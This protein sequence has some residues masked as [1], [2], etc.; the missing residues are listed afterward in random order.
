MVLDTR[1]PLQVQTPDFAGIYADTLKARDQ[2]M[3]AA[4]QQEEMAMAKQQKNR[5]AQVYSQAVNPQTGAV[6]RNMLFKGLAGAGRGDLVPTLQTEFAQ[7]DKAQ[8]EAAQKK[9]ELDILNTRTAREEVARA[10]GKNDAVDVARRF[11]AKGVLDPETA[12]S[13]VQSI[14]DDPKGFKQWQRNFSMQL[15]DAEKRMDV[16]YKQGSLAVQQGQLNV[17]RGNLAVNQGRLAL[18]AIKASREPRLG[19]PKP[20]TAA[21]DAKLR[22]T[23]S[24][25]FTAT[26]TLINNALDPKG[27]V[28]GAVND[29]RALKPSQKEAVTGF[30]AYFKSVRASSRDADRVLKNLEGKVTEMGKAAAASTGAIGSM[31]IQEWTILRDMV[32]NLNYAGMTPEGLEE[33]LGLIESQAKRAADVVQRA[34]QDQYMEEFDRYPGRFELRVPSSAPANKDVDANNPL[35]R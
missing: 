26:Q 1:I 7:Q 24:K 34:Y 13:I 11:V 15:L 25:D 33:Q 6:D 29:V 3:L 21:Q 10:M 27:G 12:N 23:L 32:A 8:S 20:L 9:L 16:E 30:D 2:N 17:S 22:G 5:L 14:P 4:Q 28:V 18:D 31:A 19:A 35:L